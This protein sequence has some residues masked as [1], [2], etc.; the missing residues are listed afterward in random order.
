[1]GKEEIFSKLNIKDY[2]NELE[3]IIEKKAFSEDVKNLLLSMFYK[4]ED[5]YDD[6]KKI[7]SIQRTKKEELELILNTIFNDCNEI[8][9]VK[10][11]VSE[12][13]VLGERKVLIEKREKKIICYPNEKSLYYGIC[14]LQEPKYKLD[15]EF[16]I[17]NKAIAR[18][19]NSRVMDK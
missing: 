14:M 4:I 2:H 3:N 10:P 9:L 8:E 5:A 15:T 7:K 11:K 16:D 19:V 6:Y 12:E 13:T 17:L 18:M 1:M